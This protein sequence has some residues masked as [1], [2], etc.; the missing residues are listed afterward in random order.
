VKGD[1]GE[2]VSYLTLKRKPGN[3]SGFLYFATSLNLL[4]AFYTFLSALYQGW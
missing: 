2:D 1:D 3:V 4:L